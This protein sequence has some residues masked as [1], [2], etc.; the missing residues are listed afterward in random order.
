MPDPILILL[1]LV[2]VVAVVA[3]GLS[4]RVIQQMQV[5]IVQRLGKSGTSDFAAS[6][7]YR[8]FPVELGP[9]IPG[10][11]AEDAGG[12]FVINQEISF[13]DGY[14]EPVMGTV[15]A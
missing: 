11:S 7:K 9:Q 10:A 8:L 5:G 13:A 6:D 2:A 1:I 4:V 3:L 15:A 12:E 14:D